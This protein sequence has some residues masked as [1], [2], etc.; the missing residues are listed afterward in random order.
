MAVCVAEE[1][2]NSFAGQSGSWRHCLYFLSNSRNEYVMMYSLTVFEVKL[3]HQTQLYSYSTKNLQ[4]IIM[5]VSLVVVA[6]FCFQFRRQ[7]CIDPV[8]TKDVTHVLL[9]LQNLVNKMWVGVASEDKAELRSCLPKLLLS[10]HALLPFFIRNKLCKVIVDIGRQD[11]PMFYHDF[12]SNTLQV[13]AVQSCLLQIPGH[14]L[15]ISPL[16][17]RHLSHTWDI[18]QNSAHCLLMHIV[19]VVGT[20]SITSAA[21]FGASEDDLRRVGLSERRLKRRSQRRAQETSTG[22]NTHRTESSDWWEREILIG[23]NKGCNK[24]NN[25]PQD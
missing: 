17:L 3:T 9:S 15:Q 20:V 8:W 22:A 6:P 4:R 14:L 19:C 13:L 11:W 24:M 23:I 18:S 1:L 5:Y 16:Y 12:F 7:R 21:G 25:L 2:L 10:Q